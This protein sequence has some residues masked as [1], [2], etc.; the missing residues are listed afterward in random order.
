LYR[1]FSNR[2]GVILHR[3]VHRLSVSKQIK[4]KWTETKGLLR[5]LVR[6]NTEAAK[7][8]EVAIS[9]VEEGDIEDPK[10]IL[11]LS[12]AICSSAIEFDEKSLRENVSELLAVFGVSATHVDA[13]LDS[14]GLKL[15]V[16]C[17]R[18]AVEPVLLK[19]GLQ[20]EDALPVLEKIGSITELQAAAKDPMSFVQ[21]VAN[22][23]GQTA[24]KL[25]I[26]HLKPQLEPYLQAQGLEWADVVPVL[27]TIDSLEELRAATEDPEALLLCWRRQGKIQHRQKLGGD[28]ADRPAWSENGSAKRPPSRRKSLTI[29]SYPAA[30]ALALQDIRVDDVG[31][32]VLS[33]DDSVVFG[34]PSIDNPTLSDC[35]ASTDNMSPEAAQTVAAL[36]EEEQ[37]R[38]QHHQQHVGTTSRHERVAQARNLVAM[39]PPRKDLRNTRV[40]LTKNENASSRRNIVYDARSKNPIRSVTLAD[41][42]SKIASKGTLEFKYAVINSQLATMHM[43]N[44]HYPNCHQHHRIR[45]ST[46]TSRSTSNHNSNSKRSNGNSDCNSIDS[47]KKCLSNR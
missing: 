6:D 14:A 46:S 21:E 18:P 36:R 33:T 42:L 41:A 10:A 44:F 11:Q 26:M 30:P 23:A 5:E 29:G 2:A 40:D 16:W 32:A 15:L 19:H 24:K 47:S 7:A 12:G 38:L 37:Q 1:C 9:A 34:N 3:L 43:P 17:L 22:T 8:I 35:Y 20:W 45:V 31:S 39:S 27:E 25:A 4:E 13:L 28:G